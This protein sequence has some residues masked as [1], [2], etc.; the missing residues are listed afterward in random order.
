MFMGYLADCMLQTI[1]HVICNKI[2]RCQ[3]TVKS[4]HNK[5][6]TL[7]RNPLAVSYRS[8]PSGPACPCGPANLCGDPLG[9]FKSMIVI[10]SRGP[11]S[12]AVSALSPPGPLPRTLPVRPERTS[13]SASFP[14][15]T[16]RLLGLHR[17][18]T[19]TSLDARPQ[20]RTLP[21]DRIGSSGLPR[22]PTTDS[23]AG[24]VRPAWRRSD[25]HHKA[26]DLSARMR[27]C[28]PRGGGN[29]GSSQHSAQC[30]GCSS[31]DGRRCMQLQPLQLLVVSWQG[32][33]D[34]GV[35]LD[36]GLHVAESR[37]Q[38]VAHGWQ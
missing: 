4:P 30:G 21:K 33:A 23:D 15:P 8:G 24:S 34:S 18:V 36:L 38:V 5:S 22:S 16:V 2:V 20:E 12:A 32:H 3:Q 17:I 19:G 25:A 14:A 37:G 6:W 35:R 26:R 31:S 11:S 28:R 29:C 1:S 7:R 9:A 10:A 13:C 27:A